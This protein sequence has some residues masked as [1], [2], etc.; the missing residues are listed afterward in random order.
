MEDCRVIKNHRWKCPRGHTVGEQYRS[1]SLCAV[2]NEE[3]HRLEI[4]RE[5]RIEIFNNKF[6]PKALYFQKHGYTITKSHQEK[7]RSQPPPQGVVAPEAHHPD[8]GLSAPGGQAANVLHAVS[9]VPEVPDA[10][11]FAPI[12]PEDARMGTDNQFH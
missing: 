5:I 4:F 10:S 11:C 1:C 3:L 9:A 7:G 12:P 6:Y 8:A 2:N